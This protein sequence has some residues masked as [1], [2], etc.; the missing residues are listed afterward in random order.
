MEKMEATGGK[1]SPAGEAENTAGGFCIEVCVTPDGKITVES[2]PMEA[3]EKSE[4]TGTPVA[5]ID[6]ALAKVKELYA[7]GGQGGD[8]AFNEG[9]GDSQASPMMVRVREGE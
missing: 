2:G 3:D 9:F 5:S 7:Q 6:E 4:P 8:D 1:D